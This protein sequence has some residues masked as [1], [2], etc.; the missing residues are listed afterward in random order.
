[1]RVRGVEAEPAVLALYPPGGPQTL[2]S[3]GRVCMCVCEVGPALLTFLRL[4]G[5]SSSQA[6]L[7]F[8]MT[9]SKCQASLSLGFSSGPC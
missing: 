2:G 9:L 1:M 6:G 5:R 4:G 7:V 8:C 3:G